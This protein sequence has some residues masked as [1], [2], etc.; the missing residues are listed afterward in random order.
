MR[1][2]HYLV[3]RSDGQARVTKRLPRLCHDEVAVKVNVLWPD[4]WGRVIKE[5]NL[6]MPDPPAVGEVTVQPG[7]S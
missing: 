1:I 4:G 7:L 3:L 2:I 6:E 5:L